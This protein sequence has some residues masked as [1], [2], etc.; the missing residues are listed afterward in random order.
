MIK[1]L[2]M[3]HQVQRAKLYKD[4]ALCEKAEFWLTVD[5]KLAAAQED[6]ELQDNIER[7]GTLLSELNQRLYGSG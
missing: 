1:L 3:H 5:E 7:F 2:R 4:K 6:E